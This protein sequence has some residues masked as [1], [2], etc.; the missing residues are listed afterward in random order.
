MYAVMVFGEID[1]ER[2]VGFMSQTDESVSVLHI[3]GQ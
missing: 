2:D 3:S 1:V